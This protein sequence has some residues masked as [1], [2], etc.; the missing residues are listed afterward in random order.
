MISKKLLPKGE[1]L[2]KRCGSWQGREGAGHLLA[3]LV[4]EG[5][6]GA[7]TRGAGRGG[8]ARGTYSRGWQGR[9]GAG[10]LLL[11]TSKQGV[12]SLC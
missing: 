7:L 6:R 5:G 11:R 8:R 12:K 1:Q 10:R 9:E 2:T 4:G 3:G